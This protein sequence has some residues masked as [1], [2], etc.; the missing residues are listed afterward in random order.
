MVQFTT[1]N[2]PM[3]K[4]CDKNKA[5]TLMN[6]MWIC[7]RCVHEFIQKQEEKARRIFLEE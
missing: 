7:G 2:I 3:C 6:N 4:K 1:D 5:L